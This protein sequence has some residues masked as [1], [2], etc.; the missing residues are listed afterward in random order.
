MLVVLVSCGQNMIGQ[1]LISAG[2]SLREASVAH[3][4]GDAGSGGSTEPTT[5]PTT[6]SPGCAQWQ[7]MLFYVNSDAFGPADVPAGWEPFGSSGGSSSY[8]LRRCKP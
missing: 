1:M 7:V 5:A 3:A 6:A 4:D 8:A 2:T